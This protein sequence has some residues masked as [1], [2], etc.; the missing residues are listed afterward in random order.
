MHKYSEYIRS[1][2]GEFSVAKHAY[3]KSRS[4]WFSDRSACYLAAGLPVVLQETGFSDWLPAGRGVL[5]YHTLEEAADCLSQ[6][7]ADY[8]AHRMAARE[9]A[10]TV[11]AH[12]RVLP[13]LLDRALVE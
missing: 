13:R 2:F 4:G 12:D 5:A 9:I 7:A 10:E 8:P 3:V 6:V 11:F 1:S